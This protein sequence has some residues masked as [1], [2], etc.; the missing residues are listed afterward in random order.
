L[1]CA[2]DDQFKLILPFQEQIA[3]RVLELCL[4]KLIDGLIGG[5]STSIVREKV[6]CGREDAKRAKKRKGKR[7]GFHFEGNPSVFLLTVY[8][9][10]LSNR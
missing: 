7:I 4:K 6:K 2:I 10:N 5:N 3:N 8:D 1:L 9:R